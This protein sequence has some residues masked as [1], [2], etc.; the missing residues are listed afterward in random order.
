MTVQPRFR[1][2]RKGLCA[3]HPKLDHEPPDVPWSRVAALLAIN[4]FCAP[5]SEVAIEPRWY[6]STA[7]MQRAP[8]GLEKTIATGRL[9]DRNQMEW[10]LGKIQ[11]RHPQ[12]NDL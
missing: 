12:V 10:R 9:K 3:P 6:P 4:R 8:K 2:E 5:G 7:L 11:A 1:E